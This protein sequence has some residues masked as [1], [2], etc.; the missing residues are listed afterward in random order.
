MSYVPCYCV[1]NIPCQ[2]DGTWLVSYYSGAI[3]VVLP[4]IDQHSSSL[5]CS[6][7]SYTQ[8]KRGYIINLKL[9]TRFLGWENFKK[10]DFLDN[11]P[12]CMWH[13]RQKV[14]E[15]MYWLGAK[16]DSDLFPVSSNKQIIFPLFLQNKWGSFLLIT[17]SSCSFH[18]CLQQ[19]SCGG[20]NVVHFFGS[21][22]LTEAGQIFAW[23]SLGAEVWD[24]IEVFC[25]LNF[26]CTFRLFESHDLIKS[27]NLISL[28][29]NCAAQ[30]GFG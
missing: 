27:D 29:L 30:I 21:L 6:S 20:I 5:G 26:I 28:N 2:L 22:C 23:I 12:N 4:Y 17:I 24:W 19:L 8:S 1:F 25:S 13:G 18:D 10:E 3:V 11:Y 9:C 14:I 15:L 16:T 7:L